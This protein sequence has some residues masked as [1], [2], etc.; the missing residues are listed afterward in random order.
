MAFPFHIAAIDAGSNAIRLVIAR[1]ESPFEIHELATER[2][3]VRLG[4][5]AFTSRRLDERTISRAAKAFRQFR[6]LMDRYR[7]EACRAVATSASREARNRAELIRRI[8]RKSGI[9]LEVIGSEEEARLVRSAV[10]ASL[11]GKFA[12]QVIAD[13][14]GGSLE[15]SLMHGEKVR[16]SVHLPVGTVRLMETLGVDGKITPQLAEDIRH[17]LLGRL[18]KA[19]G[20]RPRTSATV[21][22]ACGGNAE[23][24]AQIAPGPRQQ[25]IDSLDLRLLRR[26]LPEIL[27][28]DVEGRMRVFRVRRDRAEVIGIAAVVFDSLGAALGLRSMLVPGVGVREGVL[29]DVVRSRFAAPQAPVSDKRSRAV[30]DSVLSFAKQFNFDAGHSRHVAALAVSLFDQ[31]R[32]VHQLNDEMRFILQIAALLHDVGKIVNT[33]SHHKH[34]EYLVRCGK[35]PGLEGQRREM[36]ACLVRYHNHKSDPSPEH[37]PYGALDREQRRQVRLLAAVIRLAE[38]LDVTHRQAITR[39]R[40]AYHGRGVQIEAL[41]KMSVGKEIAA[42]QRRAELFEREFRAQAVFR[43]VA[44]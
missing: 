17:A 31:L 11:S 2:V 8:E 34:G 35:I 25:G 3:A 19:L 32:P 7:V 4:H 39:L 10:L 12:P 1:A 28:R 22:V 36:V 38:G 29:L 13:L 43:R 27:G 16:K 20:R 18:G 41:A 9:R 21:A 26:R 5:N 37:K 42:A 14:G 33:R 15:V 6:D 40:A 24:L 23:A 44:S 30:L